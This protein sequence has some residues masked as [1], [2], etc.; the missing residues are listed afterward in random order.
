[1]GVLKR[2]FKINYYYN[3]YL[4]ET[5]LKLDFCLLE[6]RSLI[7]SKSKKQKAKKTE[8]KHCN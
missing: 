8:I 4:F 6:F 7:Y 1:M 2:D 3:L 5:I